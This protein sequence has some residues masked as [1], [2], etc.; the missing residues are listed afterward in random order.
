MKTR[1]TTVM[2]EMSDTTSMAG[3]DGLVEVGCI[4]DLVYMCIHVVWQCPKDIP[5]SYY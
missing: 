3:G 1:D 2:V 5:G 4:Q